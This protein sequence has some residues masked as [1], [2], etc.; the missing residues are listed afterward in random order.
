MADTHDSATVSTAPRTGDRREQIID[1]AM[2]LFAVHGAAGTSMRTLADAVGIKAASLYNHFSS[3]DEIIDVV[4]DRGVRSF[5]RLVTHHAGLDGL[6]PTET[7][8]SCV[9]FWLML[10]EENQEIV[11]LFSREP[12]LLDADRTQD[13]TE[14][15]QELI[16]FFERL[17]DDGIRAGDFR[18]ADPHLVA[19]N[20]WGLGLAWIL[21]GQLLRQPSTIEEYA[22]RQAQLVITEISINTG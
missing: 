8:R 6:G 1:T 13:F 9:E 14:S 5:D 12:L 22:R 11:L 2:R 4:V 3:K 21:R 18:T 16:S 19:F 7:L 10:C 20:I 15:T 17:I